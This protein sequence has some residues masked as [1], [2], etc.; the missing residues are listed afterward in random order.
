MD[1]SNI[2]N[3]LFITCLTSSGLLDVTQLTLSA[4]NKFEVYQKAGCK[5]FPLNEQQL[6]VLHCSVDSSQTF[7][8]SC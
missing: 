3:I 7:S 2:Q 6:S 4:V 1:H 8:A 5:R